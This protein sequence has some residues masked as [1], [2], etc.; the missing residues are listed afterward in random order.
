MPYRNA[1]LIIAVIMLVSAAL[2]LITRF[3]IRRDQNEAEAKI[4]PAAGL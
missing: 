1:L 2:P 4:R 3:L